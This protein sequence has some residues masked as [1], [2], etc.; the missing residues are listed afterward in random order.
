[1]SRNAVFTVTICVS[2]AA[3]TPR[4]VAPPTAPAITPASDVVL[5]SANGIETLASGICVARTAPQLTTKVVIAADGQEISPPIFR[6]QTRPVQEVLAAGTRFTTL[7][8]F[9]YSP[10]RLMTLQR[11]LMARQTYFGPIT[12]VLDDATGAAI[13]AFQAPLGFDSPILERGVAQTL[14]II[15]FDLEEDPAPFQR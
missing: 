10:E 13:Q 7:C 4:S 5:Q 1:M 12:G 11:A 6:N 2:V 8:P 14:G 15:P 9:E 3:C